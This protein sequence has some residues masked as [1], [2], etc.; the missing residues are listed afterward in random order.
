MKSG[1]ENLSK[2]QNEF[3]ENKN[4]EVFF[5]KFFKSLNQY[6]KEKRNLSLPGREQEY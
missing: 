5:V 6:N 4:K 3:S 1:C 2:V